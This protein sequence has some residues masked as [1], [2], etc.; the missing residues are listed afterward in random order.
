[1]G[2]W[3]NQPMAG[4]YP[5]DIQIEFRERILDS[6]N[7][8]LLSQFNEDNNEPLEVGKVYNM[9]D[10]DISKYEKNM[11]DFTNWL[12]NQCNT[13]EESVLNE[14][15]SIYIQSATENGFHSADKNH[16]AFIIPL[17]FL[18]WNIKLNSKS[19]LSKF[20]LRVLKCTDGGSEDRGY[21]IEE[22]V[23]PN[24]INTPNDF[25]RTYIDKWDDLISGKIAMKD[26]ISTEKQKHLGKNLYNTR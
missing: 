23:Y 26:I 1:M 12:Q 10:I 20:L 18:E 25:I 21:S 17:S 7:F 16:M 11:K 19:K 13:N 9:R 2:Y 6:L 22:N 14:I 8:E 4:D 5:E 15:A 24:G 3:S